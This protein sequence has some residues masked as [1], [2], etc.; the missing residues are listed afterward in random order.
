MSVGEKLR[1]AGNTPVHDLFIKGVQFHNILSL[2]QFCFDV[3][4]YVNNVGEVFEN[5][6]FCVCMTS[7]A[8]VGRVLLTWLL[9]RQVSAPM[10]LPSMP[11]DFHLLK[12]IGGVS[13]SA[14]SLSS[15]VAHST[16]C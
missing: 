4:T 12:G 6:S 1:R 15:K 13:A 2:N 14:A 10:Q 7:T 16:C 5:M 11:F 8:C 3:H 9:Q